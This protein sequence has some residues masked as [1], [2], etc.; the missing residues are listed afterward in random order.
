MKKTDFDEYLEKQLKDPAFDE[1]FEQAG[2]AWDCAAAPSGTSQ[3]VIRS[4]D[5]DMQVGR[6]LLDS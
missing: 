5:K 1:R 6:S 4:K 2:A 3:G